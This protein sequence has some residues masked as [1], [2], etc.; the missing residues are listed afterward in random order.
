MSSSTLDP[1]NRPERDREVGKG[2]GTRNLGPSD[3]SD[4][5]S[6]VQDSMRWTNEADIGLE[7]GTLGDPD[8]APRDRTAGPDIGDAGL[9]S[10]TDSGGSGEVASAGRDTDVEIA[11][12]IDTDRVDTLGPTDNDVEARAEDADEGVPTAGRAADRDA[13]QRH[14]R[15]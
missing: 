1:E 6:D 14:R 10:D 2:H 3:T 5:G 9:D 8:S 12:D 15:R 11:H 7:K 4:S 13:A